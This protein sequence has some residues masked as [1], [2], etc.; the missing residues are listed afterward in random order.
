[1]TAAEGRTIDFRCSDARHE[2]LKQE[3]CVT[4]QA[5]QFHFSISTE[6]VCGLKL[7]QGYR[8]EGVV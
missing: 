2:K 4:E 1:M 5:H 6:P 3:I 7:V 8:A